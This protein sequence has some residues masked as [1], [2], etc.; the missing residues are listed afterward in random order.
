MKVK[1]CC[2][3]T[4]CR[5]VTHPNTAANMD[6]VEDAIETWKT[7]IRLLRE[8]GGQLPPDHQLR[9]TLIHVLPIDI[10]AYVTMHLELP[11]YA[12]YES[13]K[14][15]VLKYVEVQRILRR[16]GHKPAHILDEARAPDAAKTSDASSKGSEYSDEND[17]EEAELLE[18]L[19]AAEDVEERVEIL[20]V[21]SKRGF[22][23][24]TRGQGGPRKRFTPSG[25]REVFS[26]GPEGHRV[27]HLRP[28]RLCGEGMP[29]AEGGEESAAVLRVRGE[30]T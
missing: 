29:A 23:A 9:L 25:G 11:K 2:R 14:R 10:S 28:K 5:R 19:A 13:L 15:F 27:H 6:G 30:R 20:A 1:S 16:A 12:T 17:D 18:R 24:P 21:M 8:A 7:D 22:R 3:K 26:E 4:F